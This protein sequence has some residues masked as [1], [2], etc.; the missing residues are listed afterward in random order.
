[1]LHI[2]C[3][4]TSVDKSVNVYKGNEPFSLELVIEILRL[5][6]KF[7][8]ISPFSDK[9]RETEIFIDKTE[10]SSVNR[11]NGEK[12]RRKNRKKRGLATL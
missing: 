4:N 8:W 9:R 12:Y 1:M 11:V 7:Q 2:L 5:F 6:M 10:N 3:L